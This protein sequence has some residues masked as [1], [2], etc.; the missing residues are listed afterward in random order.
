MLSSETRIE[1][2]QPRLF[3]GKAV[4]VVC[5]YGLFLCIP[6]FIS[7]LAVS[8]RKFGFFSFFYPLLVMAATAFFLPFGFGNPYIARLIRTLL[9]PAWNREQSFIVQ[10]TTQPRIRSGVRAIVEDADDIGWLNLEATELV[11]NGDSIK[12]SIPFAQIER[13]K[14]RNVGL[15]GLFVY[16]AISLMVPSLP[17]IESIQ[18]AERSSCLLPASKRIT[19]ELFECLALRVQSC[20]PAQTQS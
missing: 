18:I 13:V 16:Q 6:V 5:A 7:L 15:R 17:N 1:L 11:F 12:L 8:L 10:L 9:P 14:L 4:L 19:K 20:K 3:T 2:S